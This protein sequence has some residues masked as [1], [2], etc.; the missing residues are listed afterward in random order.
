MGNLARLLVV[1]AAAFCSLATSCE[2]DYVPDAGSGGGDGASGGDGG[3]GITYE[4]A[5]FPS[6]LDRIVIVKADELLDICAGVRLVYPGESMAFGITSPEN[7][8]VELAYVTQDAF[9]CE[10]TPFPVDTV[11]TTSGSGEVRFTVEAGQVYPTKLTIDA[12]LNFTPEQEWVPDT[13]RMIATEV[14]VSF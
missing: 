4:A 9:E 1:L 12:R 14:E 2:S 3:S 7:W 10:A 6:A 11:M 8:S 5:G 13:V